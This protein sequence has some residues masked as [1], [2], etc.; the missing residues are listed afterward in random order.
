MN[1]DTRNSLDLFDSPVRSAGKERVIFTQADI[2]RQLDAGAFV[3]GREEA[4]AAGFINPQ[5]E[6]DTVIVDIRREEA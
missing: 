1:A 6:P 5:D 4:I 2:E 3:M